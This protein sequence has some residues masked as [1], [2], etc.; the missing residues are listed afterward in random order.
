MT[1]RPDASPELGPRRKESS[2]GSPH[3][4]QK[5]RSARRRAPANR[6]KRARGHPGV[7]RGLLAAVTELAAKDV[8][9][10]QIAHVLA[11][12]VREGELEEADA[13]RILRH[14]LRRRNTNSALGIRK[15]SHGAQASIDKYSPGLPPKNNSPDALHADHVYPLTGVLLRKVDT[16]DQWIVELRRL[17]A[18]VC[19]TAA[20]NYRLETIEQSGTTGPEKYAEAGVTFLDVE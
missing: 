11:R 8:R 4:W 14:E 13:L 16:V 20:E 12:A 18:V 3:R 6:A 10:A 15:R 17:R 2:R 1:S 5:G 9:A 7:P 19:V